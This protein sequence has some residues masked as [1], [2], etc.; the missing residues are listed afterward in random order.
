MLTQTEQ[1]LQVSTHKI[2]DR[3]TPKAN[4]GDRICVPFA[5]IVEVVDKNVCA[6]GQTWLLV[7]PNSGSYTEEWLLETEEDVQQPTELQLPSQEEKDFEQDT[8]KQLHLIDTKNESK[9]ST[10]YLESYKR[11]VAP[12]IP[13][14][15]AAWLSWSVSYND[16]WQIY[17]VWVGDRAIGKAL[18]HE[19]A[20]SMGQKYVALLL[21][22]FNRSVGKRY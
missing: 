2:W 14:T 20:E 18:T 19:E 8:T 16:N 15:V 6:N 17:W 22:S 1:S 5:P 3:E 10:K 13:K 4:I 21:G 12:V 11:S 7:K 9:Y